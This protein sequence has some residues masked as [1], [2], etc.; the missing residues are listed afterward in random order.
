MDT[1]DVDIE[2]MYAVCGDTAAIAHL[3]ATTP[4][5]F[6]FQSSPFHTHATISIADGGPVVKDGHM[7]VSTDQS[8]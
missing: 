6:H 3:A 5:G 7:S 1:R 8:V 4:T 2:R